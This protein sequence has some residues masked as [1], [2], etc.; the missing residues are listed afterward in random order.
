MQDKGR[1]RLGQVDESGEGLE[2]PGGEGSAGTEQEPG[3]Q[4]LP[5][6][7]RPCAGRWA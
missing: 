7:G 6:G 3:A 1:E 5:T 4:T 2:R